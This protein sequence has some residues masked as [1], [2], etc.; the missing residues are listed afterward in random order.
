M[1]DANGN[2]NFPIASVLKN[3]VFYKVPGHYNHISLIIL[4]TLEG[5]PK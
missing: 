3:V 2:Y 4:K 5:I 1:C